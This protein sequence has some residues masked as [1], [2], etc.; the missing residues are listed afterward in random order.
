MTRNQSIGLAAVVAIVAIAA[1]ML[2]SRVLLDGAGGG[3]TLAKATLLEPPRPLP[4]LSF[5]D[6]QGQPFGPERLRGR[7]SILFFG[8]THCPDVCPTTLALLAQVEKQLTDLPAEHQPQIILMSVDPERDT[9]ER[10]ARYVESFSPT[11]TGVTEGRAPEGERS[12]E[13]IP[14]E[15]GERQAMHEFALKLGVPVAITQLP[16]GG[17]TVDHSAAIFIIDPSG[18]LRALSSTPHS[19]P[20][21]ASD[22]RSIVAAYPQS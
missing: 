20:I 15:T 16:G 9:P 19:V 3:P 22:Y 17:Y 21:I 10:L 12:P 14:R 4:P 1:G 6:Q 2:L 11:F 18:S 5:V 8:F 7:W 13:G